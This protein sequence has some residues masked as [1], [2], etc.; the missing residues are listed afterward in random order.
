M[1]LT[2][3]TVL[4]AGLGQSGL[5][6]CH[7]LL[8]GGARV[9]ASDSN[10]ISFDNNEF[11]EEELHNIVFETGTHSQQF[12]KDIDCA[13]ISPGIKLNSPLVTWLYQNQIPVW[14]EIELASRFCRGTIIGITGS[15]GKTTSTAWI[16]HILHH[17]GVSAVAAGNIGYAFSRAVLEKADTDF[18][19]LELSSFQ[20]QSIVDFKPHIAVLLN[21]SPDHLDVHADMHEYTHAKVQLFKN[22]THN[23]WAILRDNEFSS[24]SPLGSINSKRMIFGFDTNIPHD[25]FISDGTI[26][27][28]TGNEIIPVVS[29]EEIPLP[30]AHNLENAMAVTTAAYLAGIPLENIRKTIK[31]F[32]GK[33]HRLESFF[34]KDSIQ[35]INDSKAT[36]VD[37]V[38]KAVQSFSHDIVLI[39]GGRDKNADF[40]PLVPHLQERVKHIIVLGEAKDKIL[41]HLNGAVPIQKTSTLAEAIEEA[42]KHAQPD[43]VVLFSPGCASFD[44]FTNYKERGEI[45]KKTVHEKLGT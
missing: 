4:V 39:M 14:G 42:W 21:I 11:S 3:K 25:T 7:L 13:V 34:E 31:T 38:I 40:R 27:I 44:M 41:N 6:A 9:K 17:S 24:I 26:V 28:K 20:L 10:T 1:D 43:S 2:G 5:G 35:F 23:D 32:P 45:F 19:V 36:T 15:N 18:F 12:I 8:H 33:P 30:G 29:A 16:E 22:Q 37:S